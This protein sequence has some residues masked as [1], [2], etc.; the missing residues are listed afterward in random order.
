MALWFRLNINS[1]RIGTVEI[2]RRERLDLTDRAAIQDAVSTYEVR[3]DGVLLGTVEHRYGD[4]AWRLLA[5]A[6]EL[7]AKEDA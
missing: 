5:T 1:E 4:K 7:I 2:R 3:R 6:A